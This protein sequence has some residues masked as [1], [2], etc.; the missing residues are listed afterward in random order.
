MNVKRPLNIALATSIALMSVG[1]NAK[2]DQSGSNLPPHMQQDMTSSDSNGTNRENFTSG[3]NSSSQ[4]RYE[5]T[6]TKFYIE[7]EDRWENGQSDYLFY[8]YS[9]KKSTYYWYNGWANEG[10]SVTLDVKVSNVSDHVYLMVLEYDIGYYKIINKHGLLKFDSTGLNKLNKIPGVDKIKP[11]S[12]PKQSKFFDKWYSNNCLKIPVQYLLDNSNSCLTMATDSGSD[13]ICLSYKIEEQQKLY[14]EFQS[15]LEKLSP[16]F[17]NNLDSYIYGE[18]FD[19]S[20]L[21]EVSNKSVSSVTFYANEVKASG[22]PK[23][24]AQLV[25]NDLSKNYPS[26]LWVINGEYAALAAYG[27]DQVIGKKASAAHGADQVIDGKAFSIE[28]NWPEEI[29]DESINNWLRTPEKDQALRPYHTLRLYYKKGP[30]I[31]AK[32]VTGLYDTVDTVNKTLDTVNK[33]LTLPG[34]Y[35]L[36]THLEIDKVKLSGIFSLLRSEV[37]SQV[38]GISINLTLKS[39]K[40]QKIEAQLDLPSGY[41]YEQDCQSI[42]KTVPQWFETNT[43]TNPVV[44]QCPRLTQSEV[45]PDFVNSEVYINALHEKLKLALRFKDINYQGKPSLKGWRIKNTDI[46][47]SEKEEGAEGWMLVNARQLPTLNERKRTLTLQSP[48]NSVF[49]KNQEILITLS[50]DE[51]KYLYTKDLVKS[52]NFKFNPSVVYKNVPNPQERLVETFKDSNNPWTPEEL[53]F[54]CDGSQS[55]TALCGKTC[56][57]KTTTEG[58]GLIC[59]GQKQMINMFLKEL[60]GYL[61][62]TR[63]LGKDW[64]IPSVQLESEESLKNFF[65]GAWHLLFPVKDRVIV[66]S[67]KEHKK[68][69][70]YEFIELF[71][72]LDSVQGDYDYYL[73]QNYACDSYGNPLNFSTHSDEMCTDIQKSQSS[74]NCKGSPIESRPPQS[75][76]ATTQDNTAQIDTV[77]IDTAQIDIVA[78][79]A[80]KYNFQQKASRIKLPGVNTLPKTG[81]QQEL[82]AGWMR[83]WN[84]SETKQSLRKQIKPHSKDS[85]VRL[86]YHYNEKLDCKN[87]NW[88]WESNLEHAPKM[89]TLEKFDLV[90]NVNRVIDRDI[91]PHNC[92]RDDQVTK[93]IDHI[94]RQWQPNGDYLLVILSDGISEQEMKRLNKN[95]LPRGNGKRQLLVLTSDFL[96]TDSQSVLSLPELPSNTGPHKVISMYDEMWIEKFVET[97]FNF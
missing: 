45:E 90:V 15:N 71:G 48:Q 78:V 27:A 66:V 9:P 83:T 65:C 81:G 18:E 67:S 12:C 97:I 1:C 5:I 6:F 69:H 91:R 73:H 75:D 72:K 93:I 20:K 49:Y 28:V 11:A 2:E 53:T 33:T 77:Q 56:T 86:Q 46:S 96:P 29:S 84:K 82:R 44:L 85:K 64:G 58:V 8:V 26:G 47:L 25:V 94:T 54:L 23:K 19:F 31:I 55:N 21:P 3:D 10:E 16:F 34:R 40:S 4:S 70:K 62:S 87:S 30:D 37:K 63:F 76:S 35:V 7:K 95:M 60:K 22:L 59:E 50:D 32:P 38:D 88:S 92:H 36:G 14:S 24:I 42:S 39:R 57:L 41:Q 51:W 79:F 17:E 13:E 74:W 80:E 89:E 68:E 43:V 52:G 61:I